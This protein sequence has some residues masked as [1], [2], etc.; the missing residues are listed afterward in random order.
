MP[1]PLLHNPICD[2]IIT[3]TRLNLTLQLI[4]LVVRQ[5]GGQLVLDSALFTSYIKINKRANRKVDIG[6]L[7]FL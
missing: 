5:N 7:E 6:G 1:S 4:A 2:F 3:I